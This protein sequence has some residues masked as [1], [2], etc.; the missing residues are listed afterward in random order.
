[1]SANFQLLACQTLA[2]AGAEAAA[3]RPHPWRQHELIYVI[4]DHMLP[5]LHSLC[6]HMTALIAN[7]YS[8]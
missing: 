6:Q 4:N 3:W 8:W 1:M 2:T 7:A 5:S